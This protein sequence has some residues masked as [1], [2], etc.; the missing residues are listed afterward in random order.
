M[1]PRWLL[2]VVALAV[3]PAA[4]ADRIAPDADAVRLMFPY[5]ADEVALQCAHEAPMPAKLAVHLA[6]DA[7]SRITV[8]TQATGP[9]ADCFIKLSEQ[10]HGGGPFD[11]RPQ[12]F[13]LS[14]D[15]TFTPPQR[16]LQNA[17]DTFVALG[18]QPRPG[19]VP[20]SVTYDVNSSARW[21]SVEVTTTPDNVEVASCLEAKLRERLSHFGPADWDLRVH[22]ELALAAPLTSAWLQKIVRDAAP[23]VATTCAS[24][25]DGAT[26][27]ELRVHAHPDDT[28]LT[29]DVKTDRGG[30]AY[31]SCIATKLIPVLH[32]AVAVPRKL[33]NGTVERY[34]RIVSDLDTTVS[35]DETQA[36]RRP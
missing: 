19:D 17:V 5:L 25:V 33:S 24:L 12:P 18:C 8:T 2:V 6:G 35:L 34:F 27:L 7:R 20:K 3:G 13:E 32:D 29:V 16:Q 10:T 23:A 26:H 9:F 22:S 21:L 14:L 30:E 31:R 11:Q 1:S 4:V 15:L 36:R 28:E